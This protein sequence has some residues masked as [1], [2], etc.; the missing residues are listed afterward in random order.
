M[1]D[2][3]GL[4]DSVVNLVDSLDAE[5]VSNLLG[6]G[7][8]QVLASKDLVNFVNAVLDEIVGMDAVL[9]ELLGGVETGTLMPA[10]FGDYEVDSDGLLD[11]LWL[12]LEMK[13]L[14]VDASGLEELLGPD[15]GEEIGAILDD[16]VRDMG[17][18]AKLTD[19]AYQEQEPFEVG[20][21]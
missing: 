14:Y 4:S 3:G 5:L 21:S 19:V 15:L 12:R 9:F 13:K 6:R 8:S 11:N 1:E 2:N 17:L 20:G 10:L 16:M 18:W 7:I